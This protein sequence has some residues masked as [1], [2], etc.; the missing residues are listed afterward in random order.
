[1]NEKEE[2]IKMISN[3]EREDV[4][5]YLPVITKDVVEEIRKDESR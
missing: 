4:I 2:L 1:M 5:K 3:I